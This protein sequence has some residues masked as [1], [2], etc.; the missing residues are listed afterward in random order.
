MDDLRHE[1]RRRLGRL[2]GTNE[3]QKQ[4][5]FKTFSKQHKHN[6]L[7]AI[8]IIIISFKSFLHFLCL[9]MFPITNCSTLLDTDRCSYFLCNDQ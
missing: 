4:I 2:F 5:C 7:K 6:N 9:I 8:I 3:K 1:H